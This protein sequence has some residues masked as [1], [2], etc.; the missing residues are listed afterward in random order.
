MGEAKRH[1]GMYQKLVKTA[2]RTL[3]HRCS[4]DAHARAQCQSCL[5][6]M[7]HGLGMFA[8][9]DILIIPL[10]PGSALK[11]AGLASAVHARLRVFL[12]RVRL[13]LGSGAGIYLR[14]AR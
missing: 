4:Q 5:I 13:M 8:L 6:M 10:G 12:L 14:R 1:M 7:Q 3:T 2:R 9:V 11:G